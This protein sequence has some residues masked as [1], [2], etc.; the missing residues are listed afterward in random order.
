MFLR[1]KLLNRMRPQAPVW[2]EL[3]KR[4]PKDGIRQT[5]P[6]PRAIV[7]NCKEPL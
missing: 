5:Q 4:R 1:D 7:K 2:K 6:D 3:E